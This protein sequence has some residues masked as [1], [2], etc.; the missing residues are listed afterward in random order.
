MDAR[1]L[2][3]R[4]RPYEVRPITIRV[5]EGTPK[6]YRRVDLHDPWSRYLP[7]TPETSATSETPQASAVAPVADVADS[8]GEAGAL[9]D[10]DPGDPRRVDR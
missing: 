10:F 5:G 7:D 6:G 1:G 3:R 9:F 4:L 2:A 8:Q